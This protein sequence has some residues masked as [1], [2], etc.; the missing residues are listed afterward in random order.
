M[1]RI[2]ELEGKNVVIVGMGKS[3][4]DYCMAKSHGAKFD[5]IWAIN[6]VAD[7]IHHDRVFMM[8]PASRFLDTD[9]AGGQTDS[10][11]KILKTHPGPIYTCELDERCPGL[12]EYPIDTILAEWGSHYLNN[13]V[14]YAVAFALYNKVAHIQ[15]FGIDFG[16]KGNLYFAEAGRAC[17]EFWLSKCMSEGIKVEV[18]QS[19]F[20][21]DAA[22]P[23]EDKLYG[24]HRLADPLL[25]M[26][27]EN[28][29]LVSM[30]KSEAIK[31]QEPEL[32]KKPTL[33]DRYDSHI[34]KNEPVEPKKW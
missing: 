22:V 18:A 15:L 3:W 5:E 24:Y 33:I 16:Y 34:K 26:C 25:V 14:A 12:V 27:D 20:L 10:M 19:S 13:T 7:V 8:D 29:N 17:V 32:P 28:G 1:Q 6:S 30:K 4:F 21:L 9:D 11:V 2:A 23:A 31:Y